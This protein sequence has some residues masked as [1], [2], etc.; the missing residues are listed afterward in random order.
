[1]AVDARGDVWVADTGNNR[2][3]EL[4][5]NGLPIDVL[6]SGSLDQPQGI[7][8]DPEGDVWVSDTGNNRLVEFSS[9]G[10]V[11]STIGGPGSGD[12]HFDNPTALTVSAQGDTYVADQDNNRVEELS[13]SGTYLASISVPTPDGV[14]LASARNIWVSSPSYAAG[15]ALYEFSPTGTQTTT[16]GSTQANF[17]AMS[18]TSGISVTP[19]G[20]V[21]VVQQDYGWITVFNPDG[22]FNTEFGLRPAFGRLHPMTT[23]RPRKG[24]PLARPGTST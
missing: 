17:G 1:M 13:L 8:L 23:W 9:S 3:E 19:S 4:A 14:A 5:P 20:L 11:L 7:A 21:L 6:G 10:K 16:F 22:S 18:N 12:G 24:S 15:N 2:A